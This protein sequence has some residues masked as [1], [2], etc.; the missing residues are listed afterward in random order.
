MIK[1]IDTSTRRIMILEKLNFYSSV[2]VEKLSDEF[3]SSLATIRRDLSFL[4]NQGSLTRT[5]GGATIRSSGANQKF[6]VRENINK[7]DKLEIAYEALK[8]ISPGNSICMN[9]G[10]SI[11]YFAKHLL[12]SNFSLTILTSGINTAT[13]LSENKNFLCYLIGGQ[14]K[15]LNLATSGSFAEKMLQSFNPDIAFI[16]AD[17]FTANEGLTFSYEGEANI[18]KNMIQRSKKSIALITEDKFNIVENVTSVR[19]EELDI[20]ITSTKE[21]NIFKPFVKKEINIINAKK[22]DKSE[23]HDNKILKFAK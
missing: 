22:I 12:T 18:A 6:A 3:N 4:E 8:Y 10:T 5:H 9:D 13:M 19:A 21:K 23:L 11:Y 2:S 16:S 15:N 17:G 7:N 1:K 20:I 14:V